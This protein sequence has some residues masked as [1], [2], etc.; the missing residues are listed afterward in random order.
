ML[1]LQHCG[2][3]LPAHVFDG[4]LI[5]EPV[6]TFDRVVHVE[7]PIVAVAHIAERR[8]HAALRRDGMAARREHLGDAGRLQSRGRHSQRGAQSRAAGTDDH[9]V[10]AVLDDFVSLRHRRLRKFRTSA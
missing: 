8:R 6:G 7:A 3:R 9:D 5:A 1:Q 10:I 2:H 4:V